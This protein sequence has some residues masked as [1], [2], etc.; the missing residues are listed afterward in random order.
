MWSLAVR[1]SGIRTFKKRLLKILF[2]SYSE[3]I[4]ENSNVLR[5]E[6]ICTLYV[7]LLGTICT[8]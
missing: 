6:K 4:S 2:E 7:L 1:E 8:L 3:E 5:G